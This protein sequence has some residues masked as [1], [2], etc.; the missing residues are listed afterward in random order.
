MNE[1]LFFRSKVAM[2]EDV[3]VVGACDAV[4]EMFI[5]AGDA[6]AAGG[7]FCRVDDES[8]IPA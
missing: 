2:G 3:Y 7:D 5:E 4:A 8:E 1:L 6:E